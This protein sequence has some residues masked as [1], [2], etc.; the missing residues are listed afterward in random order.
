[1]ILKIVGS[2]EF[3]SGKTP[4]RLS[5]PKDCAS[6][7]WN[8]AKATQVIISYTYLQ[9][10]GLGSIVL[11]MVLGY[12]PTCTC[13]TLFSLSEALAPQ[14]VFTYREISLLNPEELVSVAQN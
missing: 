1:M 9:D 14:A 10:R 11:A 5:T 8:Q 12:M 2:V 3:S 7:E 13:W 6:V 4:F